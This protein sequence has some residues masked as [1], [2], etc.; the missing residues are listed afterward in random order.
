MT[1]HA[2]GA[3]ESVDAESGVVAVRWEPYSEPR[4]WY[5]FTYVAALSRID[6]SHR[7]SGPVSRFIFE[8][9]E[10]DMDFYLRDDPYWTTRYLRAAGIHWIPWFTRSSRT[11]SSTYKDDRSE[12]VSMIVGF[13][14]ESNPSCRPS[15][16]I[17][18]EDWSKT[19]DSRYRPLHRHSAF[20]R[21]ITDDNRQAIIREVR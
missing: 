17:R 11:G 7:S 10:Q 3:V 2:V 19:T 13:A 4:D 15:W 16:A 14:Q 6:S 21:G 20:N 18:Y 9:E 1:I 5:F 8:G 12:L